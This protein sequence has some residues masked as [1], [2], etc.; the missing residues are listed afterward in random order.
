MAAVT[1]HSNVTI[2][3]DGEFVSSEPCYELP[4]NSRSPVHIGKSLDF[5]AGICGL[6]RDV[7]IYTHAL[8]LEEI[9]HIIKSDQPPELFSVAVSDVPRQ[10]LS[11]HED[12][13]SLYKPLRV[14]IFAEECEPFK[15]LAA[16]ILDWRPGTLF[17][18]ALFSFSFALYLL[19]KGCDPLNVAAIPL[20]STF[21]PNKRRVI[22]C[23]D[24]KGGYLEDRFPQGTTT[25]GY[26]FHYWK[27]SILCHNYVSA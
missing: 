25:I 20:S 9:K 1:H 16:G 13:A 21:L 18:F 7:R 19:F 27:V 15:S 6:V 10:Q 2:F 12:G 4:R 17:F 23:H 22:H 8:S 14:P 3:V 11:Q 5:R 26:N 24:M